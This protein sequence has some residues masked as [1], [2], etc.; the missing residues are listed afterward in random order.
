MDKFKKKA[1]GSADSAATGGGNG[2]QAMSGQDVD[3]TPGENGAVDEADPY[4]ISLIQTNAEVN[5]GEGKLIADGVDG[6]GEKLELYEIEGQQAIRG[7]TIE[8]EMRLA[9]TGEVQD[10]AG[11]I[12]MD[13]PD[14]SESAFAGYRLQIF[15]TFQELV[16]SNM[17]IHANLE[18]GGVPGMRDINASK[19]VKADDSEWDCECKE[20]FIHPNPQ[21]S[22]PKCG[23]QHEV[24]EKKRQARIQKIREQVTGLSITAAQKDVVQEVID[25]VMA[26][27]DDFI[28]SMGHL[29]KHDWDPGSSWDMVEA[30]DGSAKLIRS[31][32]SP[33]PMPKTAHTYRIGQ[34]LGIDTPI[35]PDRVTIRE[36]VG[37]HEY[38]VQSEVTGRMFVAA[39]TDLYN[40]GMEENL[41]NEG[42]PGIGFLGT[43]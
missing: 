35:M 41:F 30:E 37:E 25:N 17:R 22:C 21:T 43:L 10:I 27:S 5:R 12:Y 29:M 26:Y 31:S 11:P 16:M 39:E 32:D 28:N 19:K 1:G 2:P 7:R 6:G 18:S 9:R 36:C 8:W 3:V 14:F 20:N 13:D 42:K 33:A 24:Q 34:T 38:K 23:T 40:P 15:N 4:T